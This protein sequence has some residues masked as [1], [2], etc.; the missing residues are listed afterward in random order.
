MNDAEE[1]WQ[2]PLLDVSI[3][4]NS[5]A[6]YALTCYQLD[7]D[8]QDLI[9][10]FSTLSKED[11][12]HH[13]NETSFESSLRLLKDVLLVQPN[14]LDSSNG[15]ALAY[16]L[17]ESTE[18]LQR[19]LSSSSADILTKFQKNDS[20]GTDLSILDSPNGI[21]RVAN[22]TKVRTDIVG[23]DPTL[24]NSQFL[25]GSIPASN[26]SYRIV[27]N[28]EENKFVDQ[29]KML[30]AFFKELE[31]A[32][33]FENLESFSGILAAHSIHLKILQ[34]VVTD[35]FRVE[36]LRLRLCSQL[37]ALLNPIILSRFESYNNSLFFTAFT[38]P[39]NEGSSIDLRESHCSLPNPIIYKWPSNSV[40]IED[41]KLYMSRLPLLCFSEVFKLGSCISQS[42]KVHDNYQK[43]IET[44]VEQTVD[45]SDIYPDKCS[46]R[47]KSLDSIYNQ[48]NGSQ[49]DHPLFHVDYGSNSNL[50]ANSNFVHHPLCTD[51]AQDS[52]DIE[53]DVIFV[54]G[55]E[56]SGANGGYERIVYIVANLIENYW[57]KSSN[58]FEDSNSNAETKEGTLQGSSKTVEL[59]SG[60]IF[61]LVNNDPNEN[62]DERNTE[63]VV[64][65]TILLHVLSRTFSGGACFDKV[66]LVY[67]KPDCIV[68]SPNSKRARPLEMLILP[69]VALMLST[70]RFRLYEVMENLTV[71][72]QPCFLVDTHVVSRLVPDSGLIELLPF[73]SFHILS[74]TPVSKIPSSIY[75][76]L[77]R[78]ANLFL[79]KN[80]L[81]TRVKIAEKVEAGTQSDPPVEIECEK[82]QLN[83]DQPSEVHEEL[84]GKCN[85]AQNDSKESDQNVAEAFISN[86]K[87]LDTDKIIEVTGDDLTIITPGEAA[88]FRMFT[89]IQDK[90][91]IHNSSI[92]NIN[93]SNSEVS[94]NKE[95]AEDRDRYDCDSNESIKEEIR[96]SDARISNS[97]SKPQHTV[98]EQDFPMTVV[99]DR[100]VQ[101]HASVNSHLEEQEG[102]SYSNYNTFRTQQQ[103]NSGGN[104]ISDNTKNSSYSD[105]ISTESKENIDKS[106]ISFGLQ[107]G[108]NI[109]KLYLCHNVE[110]PDSC[111]LTSNIYIASSENSSNLANDLCNLPADSIGAIDQENQQLA[112]FLQSKR[113]I[114]Q[115]GIFNIINT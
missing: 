6:P 114:S 41:Y 28:G 49:I 109:P 90:E 22:E 64:I 51:I 45:F 27:S 107:S 61:N 13:I 14:K 58:G 87:C 60:S 19:D 80:I 106:C 102:N 93:L 98:V 34:D 62:Y 84:C 85:T 46:I 97:E 15:N 89:N 3:P 67:N 33:L 4:Y 56:Y 24:N 112:L 105:Y 99:P 71:N 35:I 50:D 88:L 73:Y 74:R 77:L 72:T 38:I 103:S 100:S 37:A 86:S 29:S 42:L 54:N 23:G 16:E 78:C 57:L 8:L 43:T 21:I 81:F 26:S 17:L 1:D 48:R 10:F 32:K 115:F 65:A 59:C 96:D 9:S 5:L 30:M 47:I 70:L 110:I 79:A 69:N 39:S 113:V 55:K 18:D 104:Q 2:D 68:I 75:Q 111:S 36:E 40:C 11:L 95:A 66:S 7:E 83:V 101:I 44:D 108:K 63:S 31:A 76:H 53:R 92:E 25:E 20:A 91:A 12:A 82:L 52:K 94:T